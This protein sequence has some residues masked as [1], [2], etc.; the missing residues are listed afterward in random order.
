MADVV[1]EFGELEIKSDELIDFTYSSSFNIQKQPT[2]ISLELTQPGN[3]S[4]IEFNVNAQ[5][6]DNASAKFTAWHNYIRSKPLELLTFLQRVWG[7]YYLTDLKI[8][9]EEIANDGD[10]LRFR[11]TLV[12]L[13]NQNFE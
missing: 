9:C 3:L 11:M 6:R 13:S 10:I 7:N 4:P 1:L 2:I 5:I 12:F 8:T